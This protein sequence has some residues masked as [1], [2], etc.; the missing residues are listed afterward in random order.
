MKHHPVL[1]FNTR[2]IV[3][4]PV[5]FKLHHTPYFKYPRAVVKSTTRAL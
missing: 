2:I 3:I 5:W 1:L 4:T